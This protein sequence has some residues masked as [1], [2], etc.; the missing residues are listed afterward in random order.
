MLE[1]MSLGEGFACVGMVATMEKSSGDVYCE[2]NIVEI[3]VYVRRCGLSGGR[4]LRYV[5][6]RFASLA[7]A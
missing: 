3:P 4:M 2:R 7:H 1:D 5:F 6:L